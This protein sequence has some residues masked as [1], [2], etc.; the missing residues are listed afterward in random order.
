L[1]CSQLIITCESPHF[2]TVCERNNDAITICDSRTIACFEY[3]AARDAYA[4]RRADQSGRYAGS[5]AE[6]GRAN[7]N[8]QTRYDIGGRPLFSGW[9]VGGCHHVWF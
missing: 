3:Y 7:S 4:N 8:A 5:D 6:S 1:G 9:Y 2:I